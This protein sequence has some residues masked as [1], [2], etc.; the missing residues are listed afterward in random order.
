MVKE[1]FPTRG[2]RAPGKLPIQRRF[3]GMSVL[4]EADLAD[5]AQQLTRHNAQVRRIVDSAAI[6]DELREAYSP[7]QDDV[8]IDV[9]Q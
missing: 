8:Q 4:A 3:T 5:V 6:I 2:E 7:T 9:Q 1:F